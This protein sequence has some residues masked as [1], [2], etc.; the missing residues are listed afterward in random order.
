MLLPPNRPARRTKGEKGRN[1]EPAAQYGKLLGGEELDLAKHDDPRTALLDWLRSTIRDVPGTAFVN[2]VWANYFN[3]GIIHPPD[4]MN[5]A[6]P[7]SNAELLDY[8]TAGFVEHQYDMKWLHREICNSRAYQLSWR[9]NE[10][11]Q[12]DTRNFSRAVP[13]RLPAEV[14]YDAVVMA[15]AGDEELAKLADNDK[16]RAIGLGNLNG[17]QPGA[18]GANAHAAYALTVFGRPARA[19]NCDCERSAEPSLL[20]TIYLQNDSETL[21]FIERTGGWQ[22]ETERI[23][24]AEREKPKVKTVPASFAK[25]ADGQDGVKDENARKRDRRL[26]KLDLAQLERRLK[27]AQQSP[28]ENKALIERIERRITELRE[29]K[30]AADAKASG[31]KDKTASESAKPSNA[32][33]QPLDTE[34][35]NEAIR[36]AYLRTVSRLPSD[37]ETERARRHIEEAPA[38]VPASAT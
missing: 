19:T 32:A 7:P 11:N 6:N 37:Q 13:R 14:A 20:Q 5:L 9:P 24:L 17:L 35:L 3:V 38:L 12:L 16:D 1:R 27:R 26:D 22:K 33:K 21:S 2:R 36:D 23:L 30:P 8:L 31:E 4:D 15:T 25:P 28:E 29:A 10:T 34:K 18:G